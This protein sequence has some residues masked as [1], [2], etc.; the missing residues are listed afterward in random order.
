MIL[1][2]A[3]E[4]Y[5]NLQG[6]NNRYQLLVHSMQY[7]GNIVACIPYIKD[8]DLKKNINDMELSKELIPVINHILAFQDTT[9]WYTDLNFIMRNFVDGGVVI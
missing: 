7:L 3:K 9:I 2:K 5:W 8:I 4:T 1:N 6:I